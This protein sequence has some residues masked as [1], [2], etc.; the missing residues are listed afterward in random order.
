MKNQKTHKKYIPTSIITSAENPNCWGRILEIDQNQCL[1]MSRFEI[2]IEK[3]LSISFEMDN[4]E[5][6]NLRCRTKKITRDSDGYFYYETKLIDNLQ[7]SDMRQK[8]LQ[9][10]T[11]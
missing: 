6:K 2:R 1:I 7:R 4:T 5:F 11:K 10:L 8:I 3:I 9:I